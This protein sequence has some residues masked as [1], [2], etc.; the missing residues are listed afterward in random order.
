MHRPRLLKISQTCA[1]AALWWGFLCGVAAAANLVDVEGFE[2]P[3]FQ[4]GDIN[5]QD[6]WLAI[7]DSASSATVQQTEVFSGGQAL[8]VSR[9]VDSEGFWVKRINSAPAGRFVTIDWD[10]KIDPT[11][12]AVGLGPFMGINVFD[13]SQGPLVQLASLGAD[14]TTGDILVQAATTGELVETPLNAPQNAWAHY[15]IELDFFSDQ[16]KAYV[17]GAL[18]ATVGFIDAQLVSDVTRLTDA[19]FVALPAGDDAASRDLT[20]TGY[21]DNFV[22]RDGLRA[23]YNRDGVVD[24]IDY[25]VCRAQLGQF[26]LNLEADGDGD[27]VVNEADFE[28]WRDNY[29]ASNDFPSPASA[30]PEPATSWLVVCLG[31]LARINRHHP[32]VG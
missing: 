3:T 25:A 15:R 5:L 29:G 1:L 2:A 4:P 18:A 31:F 27:G 32:K 30:T 12:A 10:M 8:R 13:D 6:N 11:G 16:Y 7:G 28:L 22:V 14:L 19:D 24:A 26:G 9:G 23:D 20:G 17:N 21:F